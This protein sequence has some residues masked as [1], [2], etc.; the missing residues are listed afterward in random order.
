MLENNILS[1]NNC[2]NQKIELIDNAIDFIYNRLDE[3]KLYLYK[4][5]Q[6]QPCSENENNLTSKLVKF[7]TTYNKV[8]HNYYFNSEEPQ[9]GQCKIDIACYGIDRKTILVIE[10]K[11]LPT[12]SKKRE[13]EYVTGFENKNGGI[14]RFKLGIHGE[15][16]N[17]S[18]IIGY[19]QNKDYKYFYEQINKWILEL[20]K[21]GKDSTVKWSNDDCIKI[22]VAEDNDKAHYK[23][24]NTRISLENIELHHLFINLCI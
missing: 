17:I 11:R 6:M 10:A 16:Y 21:S 9:K 5:E 2:T 14:Q 4:E 18:A 22:T 7:L 8:E 19:V 3:W 13:M 12:P 15:N 24:N 20:V 1:H 23:S